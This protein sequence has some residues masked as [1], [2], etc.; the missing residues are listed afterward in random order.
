MN[1]VAV[2]VDATIQYL[3]GSMTSIERLTFLTSANDASVEQIQSLTLKSQSIVSGAFGDVW[4]LLQGV[5]RKAVN[6]RAIACLCDVKKSGR[7]AVPA[8]TGIDRASGWAA[9]ACV[10]S[11]LGNFASFCHTR[12]ISV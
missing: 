10:S 11:A 3:L 6:R 5:D 1:D 8:T 9:P 12:S 7:G 2:K 4:V